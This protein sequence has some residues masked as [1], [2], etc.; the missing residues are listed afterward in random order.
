MDLLPTSDRTRVTRLPYRQVHDRRVLH[1]IL[2]AGLVAHVG[3]VDRVMTR[4][5]VS[6]TRCIIVSNE[7]GMGVVPESPLGRAFRDLAGRAH[8]RL[9]A[10]SSA[11]YLAMMGLVLR[12]KPGPVAK[13]LP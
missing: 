3:V 9:A 12:A 6:D 11:V 1:E 10:R 7:V 13:L 5:L 4:V 2:D 8:Q